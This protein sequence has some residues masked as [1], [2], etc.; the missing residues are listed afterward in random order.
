MRAKH[1]LDANENQVA[2]ETSHAQPRRSRERSPRPR[3]SSCSR[4]SPTPSPKPGR[5]TVV[6]RARGRG[7]PRPK[8]RKRSYDRVGA[9]ENT[10]EKRPRRS[11]TPAKDTRK[12]IHE[13]SSSS[14]D[15]LGAPPSVNIDPF[16]PPGI[17]VGSPC[18]SSSSPV[19]PQVKVG[20]M[21]D[22]E[23]EQEMV[24]AAFS[25]KLVHPN[26]CVERTAAKFYVPRSEVARWK[27]DT[28]ELLST[29]CFSSVAL[30]MLRRRA[31]DP[32]DPPNKGGSNK[33]NGRA[34]SCPP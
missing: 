10:A 23:T 15:S 25:Q 8:E 9:A 27:P 11:L 17:V 22:S 29:G 33:R 32:Q 31:R 28:I 2:P 19:R 13:T 12:I 14:N 3:G 20:P 1:G 34:S 30:N 26:G 5:S 24:V 4:R 6:G 16:N 7:V 18:P 21:S